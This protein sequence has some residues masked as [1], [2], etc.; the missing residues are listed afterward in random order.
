MEHK[1]VALVTEVSKM[2]TKVVKRDGREQPF[3]PSKITNAIKKALKAIDKEDH[4]LALSLT[5]QVIN[6]LTKH[7]VDKPTVPQIQEMVENSL[8]DTGHY[9]V[10]RAY[11]IYRNDRDRIREADTK[12]MKELLK[13]LETRD[14][15]NANVNGDA[16]MGKMLKGGSEAMKEVYLNHFAK[17]EHSQAHRNGY[18][19][20][21]DADFAA[22]G[23]TTCLQIPLD[24]LL[25][26]GFNTGHG[27]ITT[28]KSIESAASLSCI[29]FQSNQNDQHGGQSFATFDSS[30]APYV[31]ITFDKIK[32]ELSQLGISENIDDKAWEQVKKRTYQAMQIFVFNLNTM[33]SR[34]GAQV[35][36]TSVNFGLDTSP[37]GRLISEMLLKVYKKGLGRGETPIF[38]NLIFSLATG[39]NKEPGDPNYDLRRLAHEVSCERLFPNYS[40]QDASYNA[41]FYYREEDPQVVAYMGCRT[42]V[43]SNRRGPEVTE[44][45]GN[46]SFTSINLPRIALETSCPSDFYQRLED[47]IWLV[48]DQLYDRFKIQKNK[49][50]KEFPFLMG[51][52]LYMDS[53]DFESEETLEEALKHGTLS[54]GFIGLAEALKA[55]IGEHHGESEEAFKKG[56]QIVEFMDNICKKASE[57][58]NLNFSLLA[59]PAEGLSGRFTELDR[60]TFGEIEGVTDKEWYTNSFHIPVEYSISAYEKIRK[61]SAFNKY[62]PAGH[63]NYVELDAAP[64][65]NIDAFE[66]LVNAAM[67]NDCGYFSVNFPVDQCL[68]CANNGV[69][70]SETCPVCGS[71]RIQRVRRVTGYLGVLEEIP[72]EEGE[73]KTSGFNDGKYHECLN[74]VSHLQGFQTKDDQN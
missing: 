66:Q 28:P 49:K 8:M 72:D 53:E 38:P 11:V 55:M 24:R 36:F 32:N 22:I 73:G 6:K 33:H 7:G 18:I 25:A 41:P 57:Q 59:T 60:E 2:P 45:R 39:V 13:V 68:N 19:H 63:I 35:P 21:H 44:G 67:D 71:R 12:L 15:E 3:D 26:E 1:D 43:I 52:G 5:Y 37:W 56:L 74:R 47:T 69:I 61:E 17:N 54:I 70:D 20:I 50:A 64:K 4:S 40:N 48:A 16:P 51:Q 30:L 34:A 46:L 65:G 58:Y 23:T 42:R 9:E 62:T 14:Q 10:A 31:K 29:V 27:W